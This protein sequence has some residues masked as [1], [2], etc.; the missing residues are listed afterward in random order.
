[1]SGTWHSVEMAPPCV[2]S[3]GRGFFVAVRSTIGNRT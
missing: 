2:P 1:M 3:H